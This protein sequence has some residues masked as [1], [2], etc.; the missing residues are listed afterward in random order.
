MAVGEGGTWG[1]GGAVSWSVEEGVHLPM[2]LRKFF[3]SRLRVPASSGLAAHF[4]APRPGG[5]RPPSNT[6]SHGGPEAVQ[7]RPEAV[8]GP[9]EAMQ[10]RL[11]ASQPPLE[12]MQVLLEAAHPP[13]EAAQ[14]PLE[15]VQGPPEAV[16]VPLE[17]AQRPLE[18]VRG[19][20][21]RALATD[22]R[23]RGASWER[24]PTASPRLCPKTPLPCHPERS[25]GSQHGP[26][27]PSAP[28][29]SGCP[30]SVEILG[31]AAASRSLA[32]RMTSGE[33]FGHG[34]QGRAPTGR[35]AARGGPVL[36]PRADCVDLRLAAG[37]RQ[38]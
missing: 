9:S 5:T 16:Q 19:R 25:E 18:A 26:R 23:Q 8:Q 37:L 34:D 35:G 32:L 11:E 28:P 3:R 20:S 30:F 29:A 27:H 22:P 14:P 33:R 4:G 17:A 12:A 24:S 36:P 1:D 7:G 15:A 38:R 21:R 31:C 13:L 6:A 10:G 2:R